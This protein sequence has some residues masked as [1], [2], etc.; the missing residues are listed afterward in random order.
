MSIQQQ[1]EIEELKRRVTE[2]ENYLGERCKVYV[3]RHFDKLTAL[4]AQR[5][6]APIQTSTN[7]PP[8]ATLSLTRKNG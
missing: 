8:R 2:L 5:P 3:E 7:E 4:Y 6:G 1:Q